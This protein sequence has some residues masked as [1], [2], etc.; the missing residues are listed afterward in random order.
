[1]HIPIKVGSTAYRVWDV[2]LEKQKACFKALCA[3]VFAYYY[4]E[5]KK[6]LRDTR[7]G[8]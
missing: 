8:I 5:M 1:L 3:L 4:L 7:R 6:P 2:L